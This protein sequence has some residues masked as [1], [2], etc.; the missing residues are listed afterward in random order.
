MSL[1]ENERTAERPLA[2]QISS[3]PARCQLFYCTELGMQAQHRHALHY[4][5]AHS[6][7]ISTTGLT[8]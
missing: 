4:L 2:S 8:Q 1:F 6:P 7:H 3:R 5:P